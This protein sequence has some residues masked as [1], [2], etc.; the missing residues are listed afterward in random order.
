MLRTSDALDLIA[1]TL[2]IGYLIEVT[3]DGEQHADDDDDEFIESVERARVEI[4]RLA[5]IAKSVEEAACPE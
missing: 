3:A 5:E 4:K 2:D 1:D